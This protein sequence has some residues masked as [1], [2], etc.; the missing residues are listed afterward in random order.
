MVRGS[1]KLQLGATV[2]AGS[3]SRRR[4]SSGA[5]SAEAAVA[6]LQ[7]GSDGAAAL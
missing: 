2:A 5:L 7:N 1:A 4:R 6:T 3:A